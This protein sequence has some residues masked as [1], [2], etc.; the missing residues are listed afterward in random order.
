MFSS[1]QFHLLLLSSP[2]TLL[3]HPS[4]LVSPSNTFSSFSIKVSG[5]PPLLTRPRIYVPSA[6]VLTFHLSLPTLEPSTGP[7]GLE[8]PSG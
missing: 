3:L 6:S 5:T 4:S 1:C 2:S 7:P 8:G